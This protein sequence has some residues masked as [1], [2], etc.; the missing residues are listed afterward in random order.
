MGKTSLGLNIAQN[1]THRT[2]ETVGIFSLEM[3]KEQLV[4]R[5]LCSEALV[6]YQDVR[7][8][9]LHERD[10]AKL[11]SAAGALHQAVI[12]IDD[13]AGLSILELRAKARRL[14]REIHARGNRLGLIVIDY[15][16]LMRGSGRSAFSEREISEISCSRE[17]LRPEPRISWR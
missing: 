1:A 14:K 13:A 9:R 2:G 11:A 5:M 6:N 3:S 15:L 16:Q 7:S 8:G 12:Y 17:S 10:F 4:L